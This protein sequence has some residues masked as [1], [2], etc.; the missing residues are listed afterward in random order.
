MAGPVAARLRP[1]RTSGAATILSRRVRGRL[2]ARVYA[3]A[4]ATAVTMVALLVGLSVAPRLQPSDTFQVKPRAVKQQIQ[5]VGAP[6]VPGSGSA[7]QSGDGTPYGAD[8]YCAAA[9]DAWSPDLEVPVGA[10]MAAMVS[11]S[12][13]REATPSGCRGPPR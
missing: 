11:G 4:M 3:I 12:A 7:P 5:E 9:D 6:L 10:A 8:A 13:G 2:P 1:S